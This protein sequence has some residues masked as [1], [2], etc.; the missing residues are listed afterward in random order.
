MQ[1]SLR[2][3]L[4]ARRIENCRAPD[5]LYPKSPP[6]HCCHAYV[7]S[8]LLA[9]DIIRPRPTQQ[10]RSLLFQIILR[11]E[12]LVTIDFN[13]TGLNVEHIGKSACGCEQTFLKSL[14]IH[15]IYRSL[16]HQIGK[17][18]KILYEIGRSPANLLRQQLPLSRSGTQR[19]DA[20]KKE[21]RRE[22]TSFTL[23]PNS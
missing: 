16:L 19:H 8:A 1:P 6:P 7:G 18:V 3:A 2:P 22:A 21:N 11:V 5:S 10:Y 12:I 9:T 20:G 17:S 4:C 14:I 15:V 13:Q 23:M